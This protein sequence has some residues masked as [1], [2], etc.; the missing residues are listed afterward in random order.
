MRKKEKEERK[1]KNQRNK[2]NERIDYK[3]KKP[4]Q[5]SGK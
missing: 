1:K 2:M 4:L 5:Q 3:R